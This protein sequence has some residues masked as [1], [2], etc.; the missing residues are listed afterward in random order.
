MKKESIFTLI[1]LLVVISIIAI[2]AS[3]LLPALNKAREKGKSIKCTGNQKQIGM[4]IIS[5]A[6][7]Y[8]SWIPST[9]LSANYN[10]SGGTAAY[11]W[12]R[13]IAETTNIFKYTA[14][15]HSVLL[16]P[17]ATSATSRTNYGYNRGLRKQ[18]L[19]ASA[20]AKGGWLGATNCNNDFIL[21]GTI[22]R[23]SS[24]ALLGD[25]L[26]KTY[27]LD[28]SNTTAQTPYPYGA[29]FRHNLGLNMLFIDGHVEYMKKGTV[30]CWGSS[31]IRFARPWL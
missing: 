25:C 29:S 18:S 10:L 23:S 6:D 14:N 26:E 3:M 9:Y 17:S 27:Q 16:C 11:P 19:N 13:F 22:K 31:A 30:L 24:V 5:Y 12:Q 21:L 7:N 20:K 2:L 4:A 28:P 8:D 1:E 15:D